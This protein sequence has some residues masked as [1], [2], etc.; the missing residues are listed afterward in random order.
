MEMLSEAT[1]EVVG[2]SNPQFPKRN[3]H[4][5]DLSLF[6]DEISKRPHEIL[7]LELF[8]SIELIHTLYV[9]VF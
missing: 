4:P 7:T 5:R 6:L 8:R 9:V 3:Q 1:L 2:T